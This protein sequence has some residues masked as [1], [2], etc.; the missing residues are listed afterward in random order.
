MENLD[1]K[2]EKNAWEM[3]GASKAG[4]IFYAKGGVRR[5]LWGGGV[6][7]VA[8]FGIRSSM[9]CHYRDKTLTG[10][11]SALFFTQKKRLNYSYQ[12]LVNARC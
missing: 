10:E 3:C 2:V 12:S 5:F 9:S 4:G 1:Y 11:I 6:I 7:C 8:E